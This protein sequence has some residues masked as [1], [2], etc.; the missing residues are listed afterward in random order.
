MSKNFLKTH[1]SSILISTFISANKS[2]MFESYRFLVVRIAETASEAMASTSE[3]QN[4]VGTPGVWK[5]R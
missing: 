3:F 2:G 5:S 4:P 1:F